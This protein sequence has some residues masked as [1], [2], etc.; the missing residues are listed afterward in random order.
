VGRTVGKGAF[1]G[2]LRRFGLVLL[3]AGAALGGVL[4]ARTARLPG[5]ITDKRDGKTYR[6]VVIGDKRWMA[7][8]MNYKTTDTSWC[9]D[10]DTSN[11]RK[12]G[13]LYD[14]NTALT[15][16]PDGYR[17]PF[18]K[19]W[20]ELGSDVETDTYKK[21]GSIVYW[22]PKYSSFYSHA[23]EKL[24]AKSGWNDKDRYFADE[25]K[26]GNGT[27]DYGFSA[28]PGGIYFYDYD[29]EFAEFHRFYSGGIEGIWWAVA[30]AERDEDDLSYKWTIVGGTMDDQLYK[31]SW[32]IGT[33]GSLHEGRTSLSDS[34]AMSVRCVADL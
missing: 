17:L 26:S 27:D 18:S 2:R 10:H 21:D 14:Y 3:V 8:N 28:L 9:Y 23:G 30:D 12:Y 19:E 25:S 29:G 31:Y 22:Y 11:C 1:M 15:V 4:T 5:T 13:R 32:T 34:S 24:K 6:T 33:G 16:C 20:S 7:E